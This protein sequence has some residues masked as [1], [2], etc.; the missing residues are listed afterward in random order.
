[1]NVIEKKVI[2]IKRKENNFICPICKQLVVVSEAK[3]WIIETDKEIIKTWDY[4]HRHN[5][6]KM[7]E[8]DGSEHYVSEDFMELGQN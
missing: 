4:G 6:V 2:E 3:A 5:T 7:L 8:K 1:M